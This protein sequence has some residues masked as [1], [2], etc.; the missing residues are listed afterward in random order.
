MSSEAN[1]KDLQLLMAA[2]VD[3]VAPARGQGAAAKRLVTKKLLMRNQEDSRYVRATNLGDAVVQGFIVQV[4]NYVPEPGHEA[5]LC[6]SCLAPVNED[7]TCPYAD[8]LH[9]EM[10]PCCTACS[11]DCAQEI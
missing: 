6:H 5:S 4:N 2:S 7:D 8:E 9:G 3:W 10:V 11:K 1:V